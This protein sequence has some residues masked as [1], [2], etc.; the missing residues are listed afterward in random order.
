MKEINIKDNNNCFTNTFG[1][2]FE[3]INKDKALLTAGTID[4]FNTMTIGWLSAGVIWGKNTLTVYVRPSRYTY[5]FMENNDYFTVSFYDQKYFDK[6]IY[7]GRVSGRDE[8][9]VAKID[10]TPIEVDKSTTFKEAR[11]TVVCKKIY[12]QDMDEKQLH[13]N[14]IEKYYPNDDFKPLEKYHRT[15][16]GEI[17]RIFE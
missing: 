1:K 2:L 10:F 5:K 14:G 16:I 17:V 8:P 15:Y 4:D 9:K 3:V 13:A 7:L 12:Y 6:I 11:L